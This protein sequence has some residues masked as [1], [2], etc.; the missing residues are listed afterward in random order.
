M[1]EATSFLS[2]VAGEVCASNARRLCAGNWSARQ[3]T[4]S[5]VVRGPG[6]LVVG[7]PKPVELEPKLRAARVGTLGRR[8][9]LV[10]GTRTGAAV[11]HRHG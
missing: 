10:C 4:G 9:R 7:S 5:C 2:L 1:G 6:E 11:A 8:I 3:T